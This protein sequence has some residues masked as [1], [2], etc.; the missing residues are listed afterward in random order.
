MYAIDCLTVETSALEEARC[1]NRALL[2]IVIAMRVVDRV[3][4]PEC[5]L[6]SMSMYCEVVVIRE[7][8][9]ARLDV[10]RVVLVPRGI[11]VRRNQLLKRRNIRG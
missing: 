3:V 11:G 6:D 1:P 9:K 7:S 4:K 2:F 5:D 8:A 10:T